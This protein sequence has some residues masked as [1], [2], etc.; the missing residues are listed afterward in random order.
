MCP[1]PLFLISVQA[2]CLPHIDSFAKG[3]TV[4]LWSD[5]EFS[6]HSFDDVSEYQVVAAVSV[7]GTRIINHSQEM[8]IFCHYLLL[9]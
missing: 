5:L 8:T 2:Q 3:P 1:G 4:S 6:E 9:F 7:P